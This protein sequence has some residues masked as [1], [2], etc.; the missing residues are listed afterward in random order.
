VNW[1]V[2]PRTSHGYGIK[3][4]R[5]VGEVEVLTPKPIVDV[6]R[7]GFAPGADLP[8]LAW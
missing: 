3:E 6:I 7:T 8:L 5:P 4:T 2:Y 1:C